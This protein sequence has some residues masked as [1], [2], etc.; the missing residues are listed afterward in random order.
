M[1]SIMTSTP[2]A[3]APRFLRRDEVT[4]RTGLPRSSLYD[5]MKAGTFPAAIYLGVGAK[6]VGWLESEV[7]GWI[8]DQIAN[9]RRV[10]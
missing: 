6:A 2:N 9:N 7:E 8:A 5:R 3:N 4:E 10:G 1:A